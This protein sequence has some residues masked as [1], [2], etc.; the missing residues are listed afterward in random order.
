MPSLMLAMV[1]TA[2]RTAVCDDVLEILVYNVLLVLLVG[3]P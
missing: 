1:N 2:A 3:D